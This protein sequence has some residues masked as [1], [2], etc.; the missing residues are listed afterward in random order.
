MVYQCQSLDETSILHETQSKPASKNIY[1]CGIKA[2]QYPCCLKEPFMYLCGL[3]ATY[4]F[5]ILIF[6][7]KKQPEIAGSGHNNYTNTCKVY[8]RVTPRRFN[9][10]TNQQK[11][12][13]YFLKVEYSRIPNVK[14]KSY[15][16]GFKINGQFKL[17][18][19]SLQTMRKY[20]DHSPT[21]AI[22]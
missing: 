10:K 20:N 7:G 1:F 8:K 14:N 13:V 5:M 18:L 12:L 3:Q 4:F 11:R 22:F 19:R 2:S 16:E 6:G 17:V 15:D 21:P 9:Y